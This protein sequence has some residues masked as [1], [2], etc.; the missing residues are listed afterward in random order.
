MT[1]GLCVVFANLK[2]RPLAGMLSEGM[3]MCAQNDDHTQVELIRP[4]EDCTVGER[5]QLE[6]NPIGGAKLTDE[7]QKILNPKRKLAEKLLPLLRTNGEGAAEFNGVRMMTS[8]GLI[9]S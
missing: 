6:G 1:Q 4:P 2:P 9:R 5:V 3:V 7:M 8:K